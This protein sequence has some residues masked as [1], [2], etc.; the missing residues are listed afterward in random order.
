MEG[1]SLEGGEKVAPAAPMRGEAP[2]LLGSSGRYLLTLADL[3]A[4]LPVSQ[5]PQQTGVWL[6]HTQQVQPQSIRVHR[7]SQQA[8]IISQHLVSPLVQVM[9][10]PSLVMSHLH[11]PIIRLQQ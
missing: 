8:W 9:H 2:G 5:V 11:M 6:T 4:D 7:Q 10:T 1:T 3:P